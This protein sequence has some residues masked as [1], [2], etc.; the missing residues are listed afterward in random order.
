MTSH[1][2]ITATIAQA[3]GDSEPNFRA[4]SE[5]PEHRYVD[6]ANA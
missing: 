3:A 1:S 4:L 2:G 6:R 5:Y